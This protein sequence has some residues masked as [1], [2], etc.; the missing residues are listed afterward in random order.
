METLQTLYPQLLDD[1]VGRNLERLLHDMKC[2]TEAHV[3]YRARVRNYEEMRAAVE[4][5]LMERWERQRPTAPTIV[6]VIFDGPPSHES[7]RFVEC[8]NDHGAS[9]NAGAWKELDNGF[10]EL[11]IG[12]PT[13]TEAARVQWMEARLLAATPETKIIRYPDL[14]IVRQSDGDGGWPSVGEDQNHAQALEKALGRLGLYQVTPR[15]SAQPKG[16]LM[17]PNDKPLEETQAGTAAGE[18]Q[19]DAGTADGVD[20]TAGAG[21]GTQEGS[22]A[23]GQD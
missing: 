1:K 8:E 12:F 7:G 21:E 20:R 6:R 23:N 10:W 15:E 17:T 22:E 5:L 4:A 18:T 2:G 13:P 19:T 11:R 9:I 14:T 16:Q 3:E